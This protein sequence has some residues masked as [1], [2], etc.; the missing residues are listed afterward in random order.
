MDGHHPRQQFALF[1][2]V[3]HVSRRSFLGGMALAG[4][5]LATGVGARR[6]SAFESAAP[7]F[8]LGVASGDPTHNS[9]VLWTRIA[10]DALH[11]GGAGSDPI[12]VWWEIATDQD[13]RHVV[14][15]G[16]IVARPETAHSV[17]I[18]VLGLAPDRW[19]WYRFRA[20][21]DASP[22]GRTRTFPPPGSKP[23]RLRFAFVSCQHFEDGFYPAWAHVAEE[24]LDCVV[25]LG[26]YIYEDAATTIGVRQHV[27]ATEAMTLEDYRTRYAQYKTDPNLQAAHARFP[28]IVTW[29]D[30]EVE[31]N[32][33]GDISENNGDADPTNDV[34]PAV[35]RARRAAA[36]QAFFEHQPL[37][38]NV[39]PAQ[40]F[41]RFDWGR[42][43]TFSVLDTRQ[44]RTDQPCGGAADLLPPVG[45]DL[46]IPCGGE[47][48][49]SATMTGAAQEAWLL[50]GL[51]QSDARWNVVA[52]QIMMA[53][54]N[55]GPGVTQLF[56]LPVGVSV[57]NV[58]AWDGYVA[59]RN[60]LLGTI[61]AEGIRNVVVL[62]GDAHVSFV[63]DLK[64]DFADAA[65]PVVATEF[66]GPSI[67]SRSP[68][69]V[70]PI[71]QASLA[72][73]S[74]A[75]VRFFDGIFHGYVRCTVTPK[76]WQSDYRVVATVL[77]PTAPV[78]TLASFVVEDGS[79][80]ALPA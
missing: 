78:H 31:D 68:A 27:P 20:G 32:Y 73:P 75:H 67:T 79:P 40:L 38:P 37:A 33:A 14:H 10:P 29:D 3:A 74:N 42:L 16:T 60:R 11:G 5:S 65:S 76:L 80:G 19:Y 46:V 53:A 15:R 49:P 45:D 39:Q 12:S 2:P 22:I 50:D 57:R 26:D 28:F 51:R 36:Y 48:A 13:V 77:A 71:V 9:V 70:V 44:Y 62:S 59:Q 41:R 4:V 72:D 24:D 66:L 35:F 25:H 55:Y 64:P 61:G 56:G 30:H 52:Q 8:T 23:E 63:A 58:D 69:L 1:P 21:G 6:A 43:A 18:R 7:P 54:L 47:M 17:R 34:P